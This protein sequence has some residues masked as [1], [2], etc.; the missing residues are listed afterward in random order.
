MSPFDTATSAMLTSLMSTFGQSVTH[1]S[2][3]GVATALTGIV[4]YPDDPALYVSVEI[5]ATVTPAKGDT[6]RIGTTEIGRAHV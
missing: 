3:A 1:T 2:G 4:T 5:P 6:V